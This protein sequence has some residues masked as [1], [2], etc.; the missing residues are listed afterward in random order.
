M[1]AIL[2]LIFPKFFMDYTCVNPYI[3]FYM[4]GRAILLCF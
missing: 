3:L 1:T 4:H 2:Y